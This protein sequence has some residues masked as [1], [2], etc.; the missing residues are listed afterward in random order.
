MDKSSCQNQTLVAE[1]YGGL[2]SSRLA[3]SGRV[4]GGGQAIER[5]RA[6]DKKKAWHSSLSLF[7][8]Y[9]GSASPR[10]WPFLDQVRKLRE[11][12]V[13]KKRETEVGSDT[14]CADPLVSSRRDTQGLRGGLVRPTLCAKGPRALSPA[15]RGLVHGIGPRLGRRAPPP[16]GHS[17]PPWYSASGAPESKAVSLFPP[18]RW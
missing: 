6:K 2:C 12:R 11:G 16:L 13:I 18:S 1:A 17:P 3:F 7:S 14:R 4:S 10:D 5:G 15:C 9:K 8:T